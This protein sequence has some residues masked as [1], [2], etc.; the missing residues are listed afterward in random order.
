MGAEPGNVHQTTLLHRQST[1]KLK[2]EIGLCVLTDPLSHLR[3]VGTFGLC[4]QAQREFLAIW[5]IVP[6]CHP[7]RRKKLCSM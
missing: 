2:S 6:L 5:L 1:V 3:G 7:A 4:R